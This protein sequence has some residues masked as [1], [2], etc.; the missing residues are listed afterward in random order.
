MKPLISET[1]TGRYN[2]G[3]IFK[4]EIQNGFISVSKMIL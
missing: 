3:G 1:L 4:Q 2:V